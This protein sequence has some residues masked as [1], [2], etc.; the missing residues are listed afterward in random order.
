MAQIQKLICLCLGVTSLAATGCATLDESA[1]VRAAHIAPETPTSFTR[2]AL[3]EDYSFRRASIP[4]VTS[5]PAS[6][7]TTYDHE[8]IGLA[9]RN[10]NKRFHSSSR[11]AETRGLL[12]QV[13]DALPE[14]WSFAGPEAISHDQSGLT[15]T[16]TID[17]GED[18]RRYLLTEIKQF[19]SANRDI[20]CHYRV[21]GD[22]ASFTLFASFW[23]EVSLEESVG[24]AVTAIRSRFEV[25]DVVTVPIVELSSEKADPLFDELESPVAGGFEVGEIEGA[26]YR[27][28]LWLVKTHG[29]HVKARASYPQDDA[30]SEMVASIVFAFAHV[31]VRAKNMVEPVSRGAEV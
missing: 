7:Q 26:P 8:K 28:A 30:A 3:L 19:D 25:K 1:G 18:E 17:I 11:E 31:Q 12:F 16:L 6:A 20:A 21:D 27:T 4:G 22:A 10:E 2:M 15:C 14:G 29:W 13:E 5:A 9:A 23:P 24:G